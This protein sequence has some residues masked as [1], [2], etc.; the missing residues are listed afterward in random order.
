MKSTISKTHLDITEMN[1][2]ILS[3]P[4]SNQNP[5]TYN[6]EPKHILQTDYSNLSLLDL[7]NSLKEKI[8]LYETEIR[9]LLN[10]KIRM[11]IEINNLMLMNNCNKD[12]KSQFISSNKENKDNLIIELNKHNINEQ[13]ST[14]NKELN[15]LNNAIDK[16]KELITDTKFVSSSKIDNKC[17]NCEAKNKELKK[18]NAEKKEICGAI[19]ELKAQLEDMKKQQNNIKKKK[20]NKEIIDR[21]ETL[22]NI[23]QYFIL[24]NKFQLVDSDRNLWHMKKCC[25]FQQFKE[26]K[27]NECSTSEEILK[28]FVDVYEIKSDDEGGDKESENNKEEALDVNSRDKA[29]K[30]SA[31]R[32]WYSASSLPK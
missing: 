8:T 12:L 28:A 16:Q 17:C 11:Q 10:E 6:N 3:A 1:A 19:Q 15:N 21:K 22:P 14:L 13:Q 32:T 5:T 4:H 18:L 25:K 26:A 30:S 9:N 7:V 20:C 29:L 27:K 31:L 2:N 24:N 23:E